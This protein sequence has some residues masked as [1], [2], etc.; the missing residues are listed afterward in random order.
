MSSIFG[1]S[2]EAGGNSDII[3]VVKY[4]ARSGRIFRNDRVDVGGQFSTEAID[5]T[6]TFKAL[7]DFENVET[8]WLLFAAGVAP[9][10]ALVK[11]GEA[12]PARPNDQYKNGIRFMLKLA[13]ECGGD[14]REIA[15]TAKVFLAGI[16]A[17]YIEYQANK[18]ANPGKLPVVALKTTVP[19]KA[20]SGA[21]QSTN[22]QPVFEIIGWAPRSFEFTPKGGA[23]PATTPAPAAAAPS[24]GSTQVAPPAAKAA[25]PEMADAD[26]FG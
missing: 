16:E 5:I 21:K 19:I 6:N 2:T 3:P 22:Y 4:D 13:K 11:I 24:T 1:F 15:G 9:Q 17:V 23:A 18:A 20:G 8:G 26:D 10:F 7:C 14:V 12:L 25:A